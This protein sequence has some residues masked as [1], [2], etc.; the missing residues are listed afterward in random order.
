MDILTEKYLRKLHQTDTSF[1]RSLMGVINWNARLIGIKGARG[2]GKT[3]LMLQRIKQ[4]GYSAGE[5]LY[6]SLDNLWFSENNLSDLADNF[7]KKGGKFLYLDEVHKYTNWSQEIKNLYDDYPEL[8]IVFTGSSLLQMLSAKADLSRR[9]VVYH[10]QG[11]S[12]REFLNLKYKT[13]FEHVSLEHLLSNHQDI[14]NEIVNQLKP[15]K[16]FNEYLTL[17][18]YPFFLEEESLYHI[19]LEEVVNLILEI[20]LPQLRN[21]NIAFI[22]KIKQLLQVIAESA[23][24]VPNILKLS[25]RLGINRETLLA[26]L[27]YLNEAHVI[28]NIFKNGKGI[29]KLQKPDKIFLEN[30]NLMF[31]FIGDKIDLGNAR[32]SFFVNQLGYQ[33]KIELAEHGDFHVN[34]RYT[35]EIGGKNKTGKQLA[36][37]NDA[38]LALDNIEFGEKNRIPL[39]QFGFLY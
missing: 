19:R 35:F 23:P 29:S 26:Y 21:V 34:Q 9:A 2:V 39:W 38:Y 28:N 37:Q 17:G 13:T 15:L 22:G 30:S 3:T 25:E 36:N 4:A 6:I 11:L 5:A 8:H 12:Y 32:E 24:F 16:Y 14:S 20:E 33:H 1:V 10:M 31:T 27:Y 7:V 18:Y